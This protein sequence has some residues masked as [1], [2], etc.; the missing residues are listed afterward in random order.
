MRCIC[1]HGFL[2]VWT[3]YFGPKPAPAPAPSASTS[4]EAPGA[5]ATTSTTQPTQA[6]TPPTSAT[7]ETNVQ[8]VSP[9]ELFETTTNDFHT[10][11][12]NQSGSIASV[13]LLNYFQELK[14]DSKS[15]SVIPLAQPTQAPLL[16]NVALRT[17]A[18][19]PEATATINDQATGYNWE[20]KSSSYKAR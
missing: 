18:A 7:P 4:T 2:F 5:S 1:Q 13:E 19:A 16:W 6:S 11:F 10:T 9:I 17:S 3:K 15:V 12:S 8:K 14:K 20:K